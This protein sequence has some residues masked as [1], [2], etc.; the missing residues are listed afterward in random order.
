MIPV[1]ITTK[2]LIIRDI[3]NPIFVNGIIIKPPAKNVENKIPTFFLEI[4]TNNR[5][6][7]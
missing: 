1:I 2:K 3:P 7:M 5:V 6:M 4:G